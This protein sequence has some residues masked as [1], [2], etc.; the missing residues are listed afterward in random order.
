[1]KWYSRILAVYAKMKY[2]QNN[3]FYIVFDINSFLIVSNANTENNLYISL[4]KRDFICKIP[5]L[6]Y[7]RE[8]RNPIAVD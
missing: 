2:C 3:Q 4:Y 5:I 6:H 8:T 1:M 7:N